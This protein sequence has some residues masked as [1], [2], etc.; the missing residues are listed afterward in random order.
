MP[1]LRLALIERLRDNMNIELYFKEQNLERLKRIKTN[2]IIEL[3][4][5]NKVIKEKEERKRNKKYKQEK[6][7]IRGGKFVV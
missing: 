4:I 1:G 3:A 7:S 5:I 6:I 2:Y